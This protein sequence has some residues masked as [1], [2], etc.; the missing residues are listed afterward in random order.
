MC[1]IFRD[2]VLLR[3]D[4]GFWS[5]L[6]ASR[7]L[8]LLPHH[9][10]HSSPSPFLPLWHS[11]HHLVADIRGDAASMMRLGTSRGKRREGRRI[12]LGDW[13]LS[14]S[15]RRHAIRDG[16]RGKP[17]SLHSAF[18]PLLLPI[19]LFLFRRALRVFPSIMSNGVMND[20]CRNAVADHSFISSP[21]IVLPRK[22]P[23]IPVGPLPM[24]SDQI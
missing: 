9:C 8:P 18:S 13:S 23:A 5:R 1:N 7:D 10:H 4:Y 20:L 19:P 21:A 17:R 12:V 6:E 16:R 14:S 11:V 15:S 22:R 2:R 24:R 3:R